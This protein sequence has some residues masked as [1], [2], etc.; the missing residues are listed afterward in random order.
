[1]RGVIYRVP[2]SGGAPVAVTTLEASRGETGHRFPHFLPDHRSFLFTA[3]GT[4]QE[5]R[6]G[7]LDSATTN[8]VIA[9]AAQAV[10]VPPT[11]LLFLR[12][13]SI[14]AASFDSE[15]VEIT[16]TERHVVDQVTGGLSASLN[17]TLV[18]RPAGLTITQLQRFTRDGR[19]L[20]TLGSSGA[21]Q[22]LALSPSGRRVALQRGE[23]TTTGIGTSNIWILDLITGVDSKLAAVPRYEAD[24]SW[25]PDERSLAF[26]TAPSQGR[27]NLVKR[28]LVTGREESLADIVG[29][30]DEWTL[31]GRFAIFRREGQAI[32]AVPLAGDRTPRTIADR[33]LVVQDQ[34][35]VSPDGHWI[36]F[37]SN[38]S[39]R[40]EVHAAR[41]PDF[42]E[43][44]QISNSGGVQPLW[45]R[46]SQELFYLDLRGQVMSVTLTKESPTPFGVPRAL[47]STT[48]NPSPNVGEYAVTGDGQRFLALEPV[49]GAPAG[50]AFVLN[51][52]PDPATK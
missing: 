11:S 37:N 28:D 12:G 26:T 9:D 38:E 20:G 25:S 40:W 1:M 30:L 42:T 36:A 13:Q 47:F 48:L 33:P 34:S 50:L 29:N 7:T 45:R 44:Q 21:Y 22:Q 2:E 51:W 17:G 19:R 43:K 35:H 49:G 8:L 3:F 32:I 39:G 31:D 4:R 52:R 6:A 24:P 16:G 15:R 14:V 41:F 27:P 10:F 46:D 18:F 5:I 23:F